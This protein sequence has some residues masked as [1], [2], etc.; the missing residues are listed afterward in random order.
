MK[1][2]RIEQGP[3]DWATFLDPWINEK[4]TRF[5]RFETFDVKK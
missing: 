2:L 3:W 1:L 5:Q 4:V